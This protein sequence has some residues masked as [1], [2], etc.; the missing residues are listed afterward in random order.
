M[1]GSGPEP[2]VIPLAMQDIFKYIGDV[3]TTNIAELGTLFIF[4]LLSFLSPSLV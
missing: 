4:S 2:G 1:I 3:S